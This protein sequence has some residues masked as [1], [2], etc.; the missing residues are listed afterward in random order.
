M[1]LRSLKPVTV[2][3]GEIVERGSLVDLGD[4]RNPRTDRKHGCVSANVSRF[5]VKVGGRPRTVCIQARPGLHV[6]LLD[7]W[8]D[9]GRNNV[10]NRW[11]VF[12]ERKKENP[13][14]VLL[15]RR[16]CEQKTNSPNGDLESPTATPQLLVA[17]T[18]SV[19]AGKGKTC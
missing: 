16:Y 15:F 12:L 13:C 6:F 11:N 1:D 14:G 2:S 10:E 19:E 8:R 17:Q 9:I 5:R 4:V 7:E 18:I 3:A